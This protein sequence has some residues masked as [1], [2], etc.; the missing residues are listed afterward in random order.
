MGQP[1]QVKN[2]HILQQ[3]RKQRGSKWRQ[4]L[5]D[6][7]KVYPWLVLCITTLKAFCYF[8]KFC[9]RRGLLSD[10]Y[11]DSVFVSM[12]FDNWKKKHER[13]QR[14][15]QSNSHR[16]AVMKI[17]ALQHPGIDA[18][19]SSQLK[20]IQQLHCKMLQIQLSSLRF[21]LPQGLAI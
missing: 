16:E 2:P 8:C 14:H 13:F 15:A 11:V 5:P 7:F 18:Q 6:W 4:F 21:L 10:N 9:T 12:G 19:L 20:Q 17:Q 3:T 1:Y